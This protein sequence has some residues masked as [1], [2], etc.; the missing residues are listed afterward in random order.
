MKNIGN[1][2]T[3]ICKKE[4]ED[5]CVFKY[6]FKRICAH[7]RNEH[8]HKIVVCGA[9]FKNEIYSRGNFSWVSNIQLKY[10]NLIL[11]T[12]F[13]KSNIYYLL[14]FLRYYDYSRWNIFEMNLF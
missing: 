14:I 1:I 7:A 13:L 9:F 10:Q 11:K 2:L 6:L 12:K 3:Q 8:H 5:V 4:S